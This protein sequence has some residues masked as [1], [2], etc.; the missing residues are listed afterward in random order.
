MR[1]GVLPTVL[2]ER[3]VLYGTNGVLP[4]VTCS[5][6]DTFDDTT[7]RESQQ[8]RML[9]GECLSQI[10]THTVLTVLEGIDG[11]E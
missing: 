8:S 4:L 11:E 3:T 7:A 5:E 6:V 2:I 1:E 9:V 10:T